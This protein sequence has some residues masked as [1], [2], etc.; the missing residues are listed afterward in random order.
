MGLTSDNNSEQ[1]FFEESIKGKLLELVLKDYGEV[2]VVIYFL[3]TLCLDSFE[4]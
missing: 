4:G 2:C 1:L 3:N